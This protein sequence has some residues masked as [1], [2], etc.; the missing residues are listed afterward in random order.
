MLSVI[1]LVIVTVFA[2]NTV[3]STFAGASRSGVSLSLV[4][5]TPW[6]DA[7]TASMTPTFSLTFGVRTLPPQA[8][9]S[10][11]IYPRLSSRSALAYVARNGPQSQ[12]LSRIS[13]ISYTS[14]AKVHGQK[15]VTWSLPVFA[16]APTRTKRAIFL[17][18]TTGSC[19]GVYPV[20][21]S[22]SDRSGGSL[23]HLTTFLT[24]VAQAP[25]HPLRVA[26][27]FSLTPTASMPATIQPKKLRAFATL[28]GHIRSHTNIGT[29]LVVGGATLRALQNAGVGGRRV[30]NSL[31][32]F[33]TSAPMSE[34]VASTYV[35]IDPGV[36]AASLG[37]S[38]ISDQRAATVQLLNRRHIAAS[39]S[40]YVGSAT[41]SASSA[42]ALV[43]AGV[44]RGVIP[45][46]DFSPSYGSSTS[47]GP[48]SVELAKSVKGVRSIELLGI[49]TLSREDFSGG[50]AV[51][52]ANRLLAD[53]ALTYFERPNTTT[54]RGIVVSPPVGWVPSHRFDET[55]FTAFAQAPVL[56]AVSMSNYFSQIPVQGVRRL[57]QTSAQP[58]MGSR[59]SQIQTQLSR[60][61]SFSSS[62]K[63]HRSVVDALRDDVLASES[64]SLSPSAVHSSL[65]LSQRALNAQLGLVR[66][67]Q[68]HSITLTAGTGWIPISIVSLA[69]YPISGT[70][71]VSGDRFKYP[72]RHVFSITLD[73]ASTTIRVDVIARSSGE[74]PLTVTFRTLKG[75]VVIAEGRVSVRST[76][77]STVG[78]VLTLAA[79][80][81]LLA[82]WAR[83]ARNRRR[84]RREELI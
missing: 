60:V 42:S 44:N 73:H 79:L 13:D 24:Y 58:F 78:L 82:W 16:G 75:T 5:Q 37:Q 4:H 20:T 56:S 43:E 51:I 52:A 84:K 62:V 40:T 17:N 74:L 47:S 19:G 28:I 9:V 38:A 7:A 31:S 83:T 45:G 10:L 77:T 41:F 53:L 71:T 61:T 22:L 33:S 26:T 6:V 55:F 80:G 2:T 67:S 65:V 1:S 50:G 46:S 25:M 18:C 49:D 48:F 30:L 59:I 57:T 32:S 39:T 72:H 76:A 23:A 14:L 34:V 11:S 3:S 36:V 8:V 29:S 27:I 69:H 63:S 54:T 66:F 64:S 12:P 15:D 70:V 68:V 35:P 21:L 81:V